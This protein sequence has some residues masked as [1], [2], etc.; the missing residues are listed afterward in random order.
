VGQQDS[1]IATGGGVLLSGAIEI[2][3]LAGDSVIDMVV[4]AMM[5]SSVA[6]GQEVCAV[7]RDGGAYPSS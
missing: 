6:T 1:G 5:A 7:L 4:S 3:A 2:G